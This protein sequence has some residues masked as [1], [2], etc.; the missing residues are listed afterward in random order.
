MAKTLQVNFTLN[1]SADEWRKVAAE[2]APAFA[3]VPGLV[4]KV[5]NFNE[6]TGEGGGFY[7]FQ[8]ERSLADF[9]AS[10]LAE[11]VRT[12]P[13]LKDLSMKTYDVMVE[14]SCVTHAERL[15]PAVATT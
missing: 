3:A 1:V 12:S 10:P 8:D 13:A 5:W 2:V 7:M 15:I 11:M 9:A 14:V 4:W 6:Q